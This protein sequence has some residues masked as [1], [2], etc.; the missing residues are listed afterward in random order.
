MTNI[1]IT[2]AGG[3]IGANL[4][5][6]LSQ[7]NND[8]TLLVR[9][10]TNL[11]RVNHQISKS[12]IKY[13]NILNKKDL[14]NKIKEIKPDVVYHSATYGIHPAQKDYENAIRTNLIGTNNLLE[15]LSRYN[16]LQKFVNIGTSFEYGSKKEP[17]KETDIPNPRTFYGITKNVQTNIS[18]Y[19][20]SEKNLPT[21]SLRIFSTYGR[22]DEPGRLIPDLMYSIINKTKI[23]VTSKNTIRDLIYIDDVIDALLLSSRKKSPVG[24]IFNIG[25]GKGYS[26]KQ[27][28]E[29]L[30]DITNEKL[31]I[32]WGN[33]NKVREFDKTGGES[34]ANIK[35]STQILKWKPKNSIKDGLI[36][37]YNWFSKNI[38]MYHKFYSN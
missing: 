8:V 15:S 11:W 33:K 28:V 38:E 21:I 17:V 9:K 7:S 26:L 31:N 23:N 13:V 34:I 22:Y 10:K 24:E 6:K 4:A 37:T 16:D 32:S 30:Q 14:F 12:K 35:K 2:G 19:F 20:A 36:K 5:N 18:Q 1:L 27:I 29:M 3:F 25:T